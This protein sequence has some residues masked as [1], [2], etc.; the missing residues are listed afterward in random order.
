MPKF[1]IVIP[2]YKTPEK[3]LKEM[4]DS[5][6]EQTYANWELCIADGSPAG[7]SVENVLKKYA[8]KDARIRYQVLGEN[9]G[10]SGN[11]NAA[12]EMAEGDFI[13]LADHDDRLTP[14]ALFECA[15]KLNENETAMSSIPMRT[16]LT[17]MEM[18]CS[19]RISSR[20]SI[21]IF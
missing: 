15:K 10:I 13:V 21:R 18:N 14:N 1:S 6:V 16:S 4:L 9:R 3:F 11:T 2:V 7:E 8:E 5:I 19:T 17:W 20:I 12:L